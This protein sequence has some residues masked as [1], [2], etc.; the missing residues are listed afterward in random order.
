MNT[1]HLNKV[2]RNAPCPCGSGKKYKKC[3]LPKEVKI[4]AEL[5]NNIL[6]ELNYKIAY[7]PI[8]DD[9]V[10]DLP[11]E[12]Q[13]NMEMFFSQINANPE[14]CIK[15][16]EDLVRRYPHIPTLYNFL[17]VAYMN[18]GQLREGKRV[19]QES[20]KKH[21]DYLFAM[22]NYVE[23]IMDDHEFDKVAIADV[24]DNKFELDLLYPERDIFHITEVT[25]FH[26][27]IGF[28]YALTGERD[29]AQYCL[30]ILKELS[31]DH[32]HTMRL[33]K[34]LKSQVKFI[35]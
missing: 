18:S 10:R 11:G 17:Y 12:V 28:Y 3:C 29:K 20:Y 24:F 31:L 35:A 2:G 25:Y 34:E 9:D 14:S 1:Q 8:D 23:Y 15:G 32:G 30:D 7:E 21:P 5:S 6:S 27:V 26:G 33:E 4:E 16:L 22:L 19:M 13:D